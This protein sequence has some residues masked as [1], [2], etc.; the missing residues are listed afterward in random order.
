[1]LATIVWLGG[2]AVVVLLIYP[3]ERAMVRSDRHAPLTLQVSRWLN[4]V[5]WFALLLLGVSGLFQLSASNQYQGMLVI[6]NTWSILIFIKHIV[7]LVMG[8]VTLITGST[9]LPDIE[10]LLLRNQAGKNY[11][12]DSLRSS[13]LRQM[14]L[15][16][17]NLGLGVVVLGLTAW[18]RIQ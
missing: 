18:A 13:Q 15:H 16:R 3:S 12:P 17:I 6:S 10:R 4:R 7:V 1:M 14:T 9:V 2:L 5:A 8:L 11:L